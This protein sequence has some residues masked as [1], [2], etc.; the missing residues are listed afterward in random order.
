MRTFTEHQLESFLVEFLLP[1]ERAQ[2]WKER[3]NQSKAPFSVVTAT[4]RPDPDDDSI[5]LHALVGNIARSTMA[6][7]REQR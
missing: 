2:T 3:K 5:D 6:E 1:L 4:T 7:A